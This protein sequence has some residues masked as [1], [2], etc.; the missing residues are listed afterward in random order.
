MGLLSRVP[1]LRRLPRAV[2]SRYEIIDGG[3][4]PQDK[5]YVDLGVR[6]GWLK[7]SNIRRD[8]YTGESTYQYTYPD[9]ETCE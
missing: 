4:F 1:R 9:A 6:E 5:E 3:V 2:V 8:R 7:L